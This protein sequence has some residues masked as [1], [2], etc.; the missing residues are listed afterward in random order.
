MK[1]HTCIICGRKRYERNMKNVFLNS[2]ACHDIYSYK[3]CSGHP[4]IVKAIKILETLK[5]FKHIKLRHF[6]QVIVPPERTTPQGIL[7]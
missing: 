7:D 4:E 3:P 2:W 5:N 1:R 6:S